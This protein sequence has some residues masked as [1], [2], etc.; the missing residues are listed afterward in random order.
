MAM[1][2][3]LVLAWDLLTG[4]V[5]SLVAVLGQKMMV[6]APNWEVLDEALQALPLGTDDYLA[7]FNELRNARAY[8]AT[9]EK[10]AARYEFRLLHRRLRKLR[11]RLGW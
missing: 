2:N 9:G 7:C 5:A 8:L 4:T 6:R 1:R 11:R 10:G 3:E